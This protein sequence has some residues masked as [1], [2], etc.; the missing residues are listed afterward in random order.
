MRIFLECWQQTFLRMPGW[1]WCSPLYFMNASLNSRTENNAFKVSSMGVY[2]IV[3]WTMLCEGITLSAFCL[4]RHT[5]PIAFSW[6]ATYVGS[7]VI[8]FWRLNLVLYSS[9]FA[10]TYSKLRA[11]ISRMDASV[12]SSF[13]ILS[14]SRL[15][16]L[17]TKSL[18]REKILSVWIE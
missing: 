2:S 9:N 14:V 3:F 4:V 15:L 17:V 18:D 1:H 16:I 5:I 7:D 10:S 13:R 11:I 8:M 12:P 6:D